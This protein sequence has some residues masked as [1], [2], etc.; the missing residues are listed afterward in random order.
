MQMGKFDKYKIDLK[1]LASDRGSFSYD[2]DN[3]FFTLIDAPE[4]H[5]GKVHVD[6]NVKKTAGIFVL[7]FQADGVVEVPCDRCLDDM[8]LSI[9]SADKLKVKFG[10]EYTEEGDIVVVPEEEGAINVAWF[11]Y[12]FIALAIPMKHVHAPGKC[13]RMMSEKLSKHIRVEAGGGDEWDAGSA[14]DD[15]FD[16]AND[17]DTSVGTDPRWDDLKKILDN[18]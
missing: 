13:N 11:I 4:V 10:D 6:L 16:N 1:G 9:S 15:P 8:D 5:K 14:V 2:L 17:E 3:S 7:D 12:E 18:N